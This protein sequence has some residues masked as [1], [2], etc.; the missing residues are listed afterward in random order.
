MKFI[1]CVLTANEVN[2]FSTREDLLEGTVFNWNCLQ[3]IFFVYAVFPLAGGVLMCQTKET[4]DE[5][6]VIWVLAHLY[7]LNR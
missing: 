3:T 6:V 1:A 5:E 2:S 4:G 7:Q